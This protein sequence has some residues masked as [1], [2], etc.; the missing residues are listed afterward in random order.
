MSDFY[1]H[2]YSVRYQ[3]TVH[4]NNVSAAYFY[5]FLSKSNKRSVNKKIATFFIAKSNFSTSPF[6][7]FSPNDGCNDFSKY[8]LSVE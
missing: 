3:Y 1:T 4:A 8:R 5:M 6:S 7:S 2:I